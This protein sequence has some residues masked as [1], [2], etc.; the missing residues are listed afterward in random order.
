MADYK[1]GS[2]PGSIIVPRGDPVPSGYIPISA[3]D[4]GGETYGKRPETPA[5]EAPMMSFSMAA[6]ESTAE[7]MKAILKYAGKL[8]STQYGIDQKYQPLQ[9]QLA[10]DLAKQFAG[11]QADFELAMQQKYVPLFQQLY[12]QQRYQDRAADLG[13]VQQLA[14]FLQGIR[15]SAENPQATALRKMLFGQ[16]GDELSMGSRLTSQQANEAEQAIRSAQFARGISTGDSAANRESVFKALEGQRLLDQRQQK[17]SGLLAGEAAQNQDPF[18]AILSRPST[19]LTTGGSQYNQ[20]LQQ[21]VQ[22]TPFSQPVDRAFSLV[23]QGSQN[24]NSAITAQ[25]LAKAFELARLQAFQ[26]GIAV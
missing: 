14:P 25:N 22:S 12:E 6:G 13:D 7:A 2:I 26:R 16:V 23:Q 8:A 24:A 17:A 1:P 3:S 10:L 5:L 19:A 20:G 4:K 9:A 18:L 21:P 11:P 15:E